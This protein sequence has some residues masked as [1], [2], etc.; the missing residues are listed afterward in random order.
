MN[1]S[2]KPRVAVI[3]TGIA[4]LSCAW[5]LRDLADLVLYESGNR[6]GGHSN[7]VT[8]AENGKEIPIDTGFIVFNKV[9][10]PNLCGLFE[11]L[12]VAAKPSEMSFSVRHEPRDLE[13]NGM[14]LSKLF[15]Q[16]RNIANPRF[17]M[18][19][20]EIIR[21]FR[22][23]R[24]W[25]REQDSRNSSGCADPDGEDLASFCKRHRFRGDFLELYLVPMSSSVW[26]T[27]P[28]KVLEFPVATLLRFFHNH[29]FLGV[30]T[31]HPWFTVEGGART[32]V[33]KMLKV[34]GSPRLVDPVLCVEESGQGAWVHTASGSREH[35]D[36]VVLA[37][38]AD[39]SL[40][41]LKDPTPD[42]RRLLSAFH[43]Q[44]NETILHTDPS[45]MPGRKRAWAS[46]N[47]RLEQPSRDRPHA[48]THYW[49]NA[50]QGVSRTKDYFV[51]LNA[52]N[53]IDSSRILYS[54]LYEHPVF[55]LE[56]IRAQREL[57]K[58]NRSGNILFCGSYFRY[59]FH[60]D[61][62]T[63]GLEAAAELRK[64]FSGNLF[65]K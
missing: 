65:P 52:G 17:L 31:H 32:Y 38:H 51:S 41:L 36:A 9:T 28:G 37:P 50:L 22:V 64:R 2:P 16:R 23:G 35:H 45:V 33:A 39:Q 6:P 26:S 34:L 13:Y 11:E 10:Y 62:C 12:G 42:Q 30:T 29:G 53:R 27:E 46:W 40:R 43:Y 60:E 49:M 7:T 21:F 24:N 59:G 44:R 57:P 58:L 48:T 54:T 25:L 8:V 63:S 18:L 47:F 3:G 1:P 5:G 15:A 4:G 56:A 61:A 20:A 55:T 19:V 14:G